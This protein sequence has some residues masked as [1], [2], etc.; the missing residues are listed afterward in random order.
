M[1]NFVLYDELGHGE[2]RIVYKGRK[3]GTIEYLAIHCVEKSRREALQNSVKICHDLHHSNVVQFYEWYETSNHLWLVVELCTGLSLETILMQDN[4]LPEET[5]RSFSKGIVEALFYLHCRDII[6]CDLVPSKMILD[7]SGVLKLSNFTL[8][9]F[10]VEE[11]YFDEP[12]DDFDL[13][14]SVLD[15]RSLSKRIVHCLPFYIA[16][17]ILLGGSFT[18]L[19]DFW[20]LGCLLYECF[21]GS[22]PYVATRFDDLLRKIKSEDVQFPVQGKDGF[23][24]KATDSFYSL[25]K[26]LLSKDPLQRFS[27]QTLCSHDFWQGELQHIIDDMMSTVSDNLVANSLSKSN[28]SLFKSN[29]SVCR[30]LAKDKVSTE[31]EDKDALLYESF[32]HHEECNVSNVSATKEDIEKT[33]KPRESTGTF[34]AVGKPKYSSAR[35]SRKLSDLN[36]F[37]SHSLP[38]K[39]SLVAE[40]EANI[41]LNLNL[42]DLLYHP[43]DL[44]VSPIIDNPKIQKPCLLKWDLHHIPF[45]TLKAENVEQMP[46]EEIDSHITVICEFFQHLVKGSKGSAGMALRAKTHTLGYLC[47]IAKSDKIANTLIGNG[48]IKI[49]LNELRGSGPQDLKIRVGKLLGTLACSATYI[50]PEF[51]MTEVFSVLTDALRDNLC[52][53]PLKIALLPALGEFMFYA[54]TQEEGEDKKIA[55]WE[56]PGGM[57]IIVAKCL[58]PGED[59]TVQHF[60]AKVIENI[61]T[62]NGRYCKKFLTKDIGQSLWNLFSHSVN[63]AQKVTSSSALCRLSMH[64]NA[65]ILQVMERIGVDALFKAIFAGTNSI[66]QSLLT[67]LIALLSNPTYFKRISQDTN[68]VQKT[69]RFLESSSFILRAKVYLFAAE[70][71]VK[72]YDALLECLKAKIVTF[73]E[74]DNRKSSSAHARNDAQAFAYVKKCLDLAVCS[75]MKQVPTITS[76]ILKV[77]D[78]IAGR[79]HPSSAQIKQLR[80]NLPYLSIILHIVTSQIFRPRIVND[81]F[82]EALGTL[83]SFVQTVDAGQTNLASST[84]G[85]IS[86]DITRTVFSI[87]EAIAQHPLL[88]LEYREVFITSILT[89]LSLFSHSS[90]GDNRMWAT[91]IFS[92]ASALYF[93]ND[94]CEKSARCIT[95]D[96]S[97]RKLLE[98][99]DKTFVQNIEVVLQDQ[100]PIPAYGLKLL[101]LYVDYNKD[102]ATCFIE[103]DIVDKVIQLFEKHQDD[104]RSSTLIAIVNFMA[105]LVSN[106]NK[107]VDIIC[108]QW[109]IDYLMSAFIA[110]ST[111]LEEDETGESASRLFL[112]LLDTL[113]QL[114]RCVESQVKKIVR[115]KDDGSKDRNGRTQDV[116][117]V[118][119]LLQKCKILSELNGVM[120]TLLCFDDEDVQELASHCLYISAELF[121]GEYEA[122]FS[123]D[124]LESLTDA[125]ELSSDKRRK[126]LLRIVKRFITSS[127]ILLKVLQENGEDLRRY[128]LDYVAAGS[129]STEMKAVQVIAH[130]ILKLIKSN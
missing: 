76:G 125:I 34:L 26:G 90:S 32:D 107:D 80:V 28:A 128:L 48:F 88:L 59:A 71:S 111:T 37:I 98:I 63:D 43:S 82:I 100:E 69:V 73:V 119:Q 124:N 30:N 61:V 99:I 4:Y 56:P 123:E 129:T 12:Q 21:T 112:P 36:A 72:S 24:S 79:H 18:K 70:I 57:F 95:A 87:V 22:P 101:Q 65:I 47:N 16:P 66:Q 14:D 106:C 118:E 58:Q 97:N 2:Q 20:S 33:R 45:A 85:N 120:I 126:L 67:V 117:N 91:K 5:I 114:L 49:L 83:L 96:K 7:G 103:G 35:E 113:R 15:S 40:K 81:S 3:K 42:V 25:I 60:A 51:K 102:S 89:H 86:E 13:G 116:Y 109:L 31:Q 92:D 39:T 74:R 127:S 122:S 29:L 53:I 41:G 46:Q 27:W 8:A 130:D 55:N 108:Q 38:Q 121:G 11:D 62:T 94:D 44:D 52:V 105:S 23:S 93:E 6:Y 17:E 64:S 75:I 104:T 77:L 9:K 19:S 110:A 78:A 1:E 10:E 115:S 50:S 68:A 54:A 84:G